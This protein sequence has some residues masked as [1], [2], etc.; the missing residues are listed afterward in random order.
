MTVRLSIPY[1]FGCM[2]EMVSQ[3]SGVLNLGLEG[4]MTIGAFVGFMVTYFSQNHYL[5]FVMAVGSGLG[6]GLIYS[7]L[8]IWIGLQQPITGISLNLLILG[9]SSFFYR[10]I[11]GVPT[12]LP[13]ADNT[14]ELVPIPILSKIPVLG[15]VLFNQYAMF[16]IGIALLI[17][18]IIFFNRTKMGI[19]IEAC[20]ENPKAA[21]TR[22]VNVNLTRLV[23]V[24][25]SAGFAASAGAFL[26]IVQFN[27][28]TAGMVAG[29]GYIAYVLVI[30]CRWQHINIIKGA[31]LFGF[32]EAVAMFMQVVSAI[33]HQVFLLMPYVITIVVLIITSARR[34]RPR[35]S[36]LGV[37]NIPS[38]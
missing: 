17:F 36:H 23:S 2:G 26:S 33:P 15:T 10:L 38:K 32:L 12:T 31:L 8:T 19:I 6:F 34:R 35:P 13:V 22:G 21:E 28:Y 3:K 9:S 4:V 20:G 1:M 29:R 27:Q 24:L 25:I 18:F 16:Y 30:F 14:F 37:Q 5:G 7:V 11:F